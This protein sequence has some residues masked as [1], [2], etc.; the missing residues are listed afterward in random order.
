MLSES[1]APAIAAVQKSVEYLMAT[2]AAQG[3]DA[4]LAALLIRESADS[5]TT[6][7]SRGGALSDEQ[8]DFLVES[9]TFTAERLEQVEG[10]VARGDLADLERRTR[11]AAVID[12]VSAAEVA[13]R[14]GIDASRVR[15]RQS[16]GGLYAFMVGGK[17]RYPMW[18]FTDDPKQ[19]VLP[20]LPALVEAFPEDMHPASIEHFMET[21]QEDLVV[22]GR[23]VTPP[24]WLQ[25]GGGPQSVVDILG[26]FLQ[27]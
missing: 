26:G 25:L 8:A 14:L 6:R 9:G 11:L 2:V 4:E 7:Q 16:K 23:G 1:A 21:P 5:L 17:R 3:G 10:R 15:H 20:G 24:E 22:E 13:L 19:P 27:S 18:Q 12:S